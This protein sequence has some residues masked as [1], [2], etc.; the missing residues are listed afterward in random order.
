MRPGK[1]YLHF[2]V[3]VVLLPHALVNIPDENMHIGVFLLFFIIFFYS[4]P[5]RGVQL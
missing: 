5:V 3:G 1:H 2:L 4:F